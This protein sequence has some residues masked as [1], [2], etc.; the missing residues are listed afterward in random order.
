[1]YLLMDKVKTAVIPKNKK[2]ESMK[3]HLRAF[4]RSSAPYLT[5]RKVTAAKVPEIA[6]AKMECKIVSVAQWKRSWEMGRTNR[7]ENQQRW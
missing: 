1:V 5:M 4:F 7:S 3:A 6:G 2:G